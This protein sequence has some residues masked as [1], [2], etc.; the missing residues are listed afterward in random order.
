LPYKA[1]RLL[2]HLP[3]YDEDGVYIESKK[4]KEILLGTV[5]EGCHPATLITLGVPAVSPE[6]KLYYIYVMEG[7]EN[8]WLRHLKVKIKYLVAYRIEKRRSPLHRRRRFS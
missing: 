1:G 8:D 3:L 5:P 4:A 6:E 7:E 2:V